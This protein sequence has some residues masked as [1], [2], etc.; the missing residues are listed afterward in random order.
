[1]KQMVANS[2]VNNTATSASNTS[3][4]KFPDFVCKEDRKFFTVF[5]DANL[6]LIF[7]NEFSQVGI[8]AVLVNATKAAKAIHLAFDSVVANFFVAIKHL[9]EDTLRV[10]GRNP[11]NRKLLKPSKEFLDT[12]PEPI[13]HT[14]NQINLSTLEENEIVKNRILF[15][16]EA[17]SQPTLDKQPPLEPG[18]L[19]SGE[20]VVVAALMNVLQA[21]KLERW[22]TDLVRTAIATTLNGALKVF[23]LTSGENTEMNVG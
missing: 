23:L 9:E 16:C 12:V 11:A 21:H 19:D 1:M 18:E 10:I 13:V 17:Y 20:V 3:E 5:N 8:N 14:L 22:R 7:G 2:T 15:A 4:F 6:R